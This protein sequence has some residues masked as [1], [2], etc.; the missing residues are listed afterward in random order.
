M[1]PFANALWAALLG[2]LVGAPAPDDPMPVVLDL[3]HH[4]GTPRI[5]LIGDTG[6]PG[7]IVERWRK[8]IIGED[9]DAVVVLGDLVYQQVPPCPK[10]APDTGARKVLESHVGHALAGLGAPALLV[11]GNHDRA[12]VDGE[13]P[14]ERCVIAYAKS[15][16]DLKLPARYYAADFGVVVL[17]V[18]DSN[19]L[20]DAQAAFV[21]QVV[22][23]YPKARLVL[24][25]HHV[26]RTFHDKEDEDRIRPWLVAHAI[27][28]ALWL[29]GHAHL[30]QLGI[31]DG[32]PAVT[33][34][35][36]ADPRDRPGC[37]FMHPKGCGKGQLFGSSAPGFA[38]LDVAADGHFT[39]NFEDADGLPLY[40][41]DE[42]ASPPP[43]DQP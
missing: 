11:L 16:A 29:N 19:A 1:I 28:P 4:D 32:V 26:Y 30:L 8:T 10:G 36:G 37:D 7:P 40:Y 24:A 13:P 43:G 34:G 2:P 9:K 23:D 5:I 31:Y 21:K 14:R 17:V 18:L 39:L 41:W 6:E 35:T 15:T 33:S 12:W 25:A 20:D 42:A 22:A 38:I 27:R 3:T